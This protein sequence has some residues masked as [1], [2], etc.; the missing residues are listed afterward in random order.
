MPLRSDPQ[1]GIVSVGLMSPLLSLRSLNTEFVPV[2]SV[3]T[4]LALLPHDSA[5]IWPV[6]CVHTVGNRIALL[7]NPLSSR[8]VSSQGIFEPRLLES[9][10]RFW[11]ASYSTVMRERH[12][13]GPTERG[14]LPAQGSG[15]PP[16]HFRQYCPKPIVVLGEAVPAHNQTQEM[17][18]NLP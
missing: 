6:I 7:A 1:V 15:C 17:V 9:K 13:C 11:I 14:T 5:A 16:L 10:D 12:Y 4:E 2:N 8:E 18:S 3:M